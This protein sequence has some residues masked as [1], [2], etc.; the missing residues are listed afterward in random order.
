MYFDYDLFKKEKTIEIVCRILISLQLILVIRG[1][2]VF[3]Q[4][5]HQLVSRLF[6]KASLRVSY[7]YVITSLIVSGCL[8]ITLWLYFLK[9]KIAVI[10]IATI[11]LLLAEVW[12]YF[13]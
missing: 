5:K 1:Y 12:M 3:L 7:P 9:K 2:I 13:L 10:I 8:L 6:L 11:S 4:T